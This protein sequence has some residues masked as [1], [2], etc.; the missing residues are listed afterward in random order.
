MTAMG[1]LQVQENIK[2]EMQRADGN[3]KAEVDQLS[4]KFSRVKV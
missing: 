1:V 2:D 4:L 3:R